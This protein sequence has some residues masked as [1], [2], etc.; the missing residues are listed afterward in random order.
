MARLNVKPTRME[1]LNL[2]KR[3]KSA[4]RGHKL[5]KDK[6]DG[7]MSTFMEIIREAKTTRR[8]V[9]EALSKSFKNFMLASS[10]MLPEILESALLY[11][12]ATTELEVETKNVMS[13]HIPYFT[14]K[15]EGDILNYGYLQTSAELD[16]SLKAFQ[17]VFPLL[18]KLAQIEKQAEQLAAE[19]ETTRRRVNALEYKMIPDL[20]ETIKFITMKLEE[21]ERS[22][23]VS[24]MIVKSMI[25]E[26]ASV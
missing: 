23:K 26:D 3:Y 25:E 22:A 20:E 2:K 9:E 17:E 24:T 1:L 4:K 8:E 10:M 16:V 13:V 18:I 11:P 21:T 12:S 14:L 5:L 6:Q 15:Q 7:L 19:L